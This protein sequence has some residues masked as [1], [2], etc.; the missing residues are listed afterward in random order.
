MLGLPVLRHTPAGPSALGTIVGKDFET[1]EIAC[2]IARAGNRSYRVRGGVVPANPGEIAAGVDRSDLADIPEQVAARLDVE[3][4]L[5][6]CAS[7]W[8][9]AGWCASVRAAAPRGR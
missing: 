6:H 5:V 3:D 4:C 2:L 8:Q 1:V 9:R 7:M